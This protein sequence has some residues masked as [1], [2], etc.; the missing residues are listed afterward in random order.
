MAATRA[1]V[2]ARR[3]VRMDSNC[4][5]WATTPASITTP[6]PRLAAVE[7]D[8][9]V[10]TFDQAGEAAIMARYMGQVAVFRAIVPLFRRGDR[11]QEDVAASEFVPANF[12]DE[13]TLARWKELGLTPSRQSGDAE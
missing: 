3:A 10:R 2:T 9:L 13:L 8:G 4:R 11:T 1:A 12:I 5:F 7:E 6:W